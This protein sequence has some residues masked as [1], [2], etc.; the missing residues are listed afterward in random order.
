[1]RNKGERSGNERPFSRMHNFFALEV[2]DKWARTGTKFR[3]LGPR[4]YP[5]PEVVKQ[6]SEVR[7]GL[8]RVSGLKIAMN[9]GCH[10]HNAEAKFKFSRTSRCTIPVPRLAGSIG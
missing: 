4:G 9:N 5:P 6:P 2:G 3:P 8:Q 1:M 10:F 7:Y